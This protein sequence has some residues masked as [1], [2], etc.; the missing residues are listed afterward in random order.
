[1]T[2]LI[3]KFSFDAAKANAQVTA[4]AIFLWL[5]VMA[6]AISSVVSQQFSKK[7]RVFWLLMIVGI[8]L[9][10]LLAYLPFSIQKENYPGLFNNSKGRS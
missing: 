7:Q 6:C 1:M 5:A 9:A 10:G 4:M 2:D 3:Y 8:P